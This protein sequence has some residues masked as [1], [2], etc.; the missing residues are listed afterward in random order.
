MRSVR[1][2]DKIEKELENLS[3]QKN[4]S[5]SEIIKEALTEYIA[6]EKIS[7]SPYESGK[8]YFGKRGSGDRDRSTRYKSKIKEKIREKQSD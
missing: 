5:R 7:N 2:P 8:D 4:V 6:R 3:S 1:L